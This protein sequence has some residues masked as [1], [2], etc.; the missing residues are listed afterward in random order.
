VEVDLA[1]FSEVGDDWLAVTI[2]C[3][4]PG[5]LVLFKY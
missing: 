3:F 1:V 4:S 2:H 5:R